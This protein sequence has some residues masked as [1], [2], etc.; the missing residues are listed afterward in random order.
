MN[1]RDTGTTAWRTRGACRDE[2]TSA[3]FADQPSAEVVALCNGCEVRPDC[4]D[5]SVS[6]PNQ[7]GYLGGTTYAERHPT[8][9]LASGLPKPP[10]IRKPKPTRV[11]KPRRPGSSTP[12]VAGHY[13][14]TEAA[15]ALGVAVPT[16]MRLLRSGAIEGHQHETHGGRLLWWAIPMASVD[17]Y[18]ESMGDGEGVGKQWLNTANRRTWAGKRRFGFIT[19][20]LW[21]ACC[22]LLS[23]ELSSSSKPTGGFK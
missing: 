14:A 2:P 17:A 20:S 8:R 7:Q 10:R 4:L 22:S 18:L 3:F 23:A 15:A 12:R 6:E 21:E 5:W 19:H 13:N 16:L 1:G 9:V 11:P